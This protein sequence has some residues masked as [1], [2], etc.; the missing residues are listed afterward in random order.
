M[1]KFIWQMMKTASRFQQKRRICTLVRTLPGDMQ[2]AILHDLLEVI[3][4][5][6]RMEKVR[7]VR[8]I[9]LTV[10]EQL[11][12]PYQGK[13]EDIHQEYTSRLTMAASNVLVPE[14]PMPRL[15]INHSM[16]EEKAKAWLTLQTLEEEIMSL[17]HTSKFLSYAAILAISIAVWPNYMTI[18][19]K[20]GNDFIGGNELISSLFIGFMALV[21][22]CFEVIAPFAAL[23]F[24]PK[25][26]RNGCSRML[27]IIG[28]VVI[29][30]SLCLAIISRSEIGASAITNPQEMGKVE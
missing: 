16:L 26:Y 17:P 20:F 24:M 7:R 18:T 22:C 23:T 21:L 12:V 5:F 14:F 30:I 6:D 8:S 27:T 25:K 13:L 9:F 28:S 4:L 15:S 11:G 19:A 10:K 3:D 29:M 2:P 1:R